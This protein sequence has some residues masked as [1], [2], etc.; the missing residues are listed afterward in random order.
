MIKIHIL[1]L[2]TDRKTLTQFLTDFLT[3]QPK[4]YMIHLQCNC[5]IQQ[6][7]QRLSNYKYLFLIVAERNIL[8]IIGC[9]F[10]DTHYI[11]EIKNKFWLTFLID[12]Q[13]ANRGIAATAVRLLLDYLKEKTDITEVYAGINK[14]NLASVRVISDKLGFELVATKKNVAAYRWKIK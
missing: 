9:R 7:A 8:G 2:N 14:E 11:R 13:A 12:S 1:R 6:L 4:E 5:T 10:M 3:L